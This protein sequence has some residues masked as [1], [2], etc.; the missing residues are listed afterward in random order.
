MEKFLSHRTLILN[1]TFQPLSVVSYRRAVSLML[2][3]KIHS[4]EDSKI[5]FKSEK[6]KINLPNVALLNYFVNA[7]YSRRVALNKENI[8]IR[9][10][11]TCQYCGGV[12]ESVD[13]IIPKS[14]GGEHIW[15]NVVAC[16]KKCNLIKA[17]KDLLK[18]RLKLIKTPEHPVCAFW[19]K[20]I[21]GSNPDPSWRKYLK[22]A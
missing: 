18:T 13:H 4:L 9:D 11:H 19:V 2:N 1:S 3:K 6:T 12:A 17:D 22:S 8:F 14:K 5:V 10:F 15:S 21:V 16:C 20:T 7:P